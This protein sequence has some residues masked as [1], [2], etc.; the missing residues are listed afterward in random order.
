MFFRVPKIK[1][2][3]PCVKLILRKTSRWNF[4]YQNKK[5]IIPSI[6]TSHELLLVLYLVNDVCQT[7][8]GGR[9]GRGEEAIQASSFS[10]Q[11]I[12][13]ISLQDL[14]QSSWR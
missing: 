12:P 14:H 10:L 5:K 13:R 6:A 1:Y 4:E 8:K 2:I 7:G 9:G 3:L 11:S